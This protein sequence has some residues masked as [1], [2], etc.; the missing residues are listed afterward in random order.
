MRNITSLLPEFS[1]QST[2]PQKS[3]HHHNLGI[4]LLLLI[5]KMEGPDKHLLVV[6]AEV[7]CWH[8]QL[9]QEVSH[10]NGTI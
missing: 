8:D 5:T 1:N 3:S 4:L 9:R 7:S 10:L 6:D 2:F